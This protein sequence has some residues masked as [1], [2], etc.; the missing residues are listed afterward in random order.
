[1]GWI[2]CT[3]FLLLEMLPHVMLQGGNRCE[4]RGY[5]K[6]SIVIFNSSKFDNRGVG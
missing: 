1:M 2:G 6:T 4:K 3:V 5:D